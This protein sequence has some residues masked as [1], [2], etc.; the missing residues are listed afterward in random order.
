MKTTPII[1]AL[2]LALTLTTLGSSLTFAAESE[3]E[4]VAQAAG[5][6]SSA[7]QTAINN[8][9]KVAAQAKD[10]NYT[11]QLGLNHYLNQ[12]LD[13]AKEIANGTNA[14]DADAMAQ[15]L[16]EASNATKAFLNNTP[17]TVATASEKVSSEE[18]VEAAAPVAET[19]PQV[20]VATTSTKTTRTAQPAVQTLGTAITV[21]VAERPE[22]D[23]STKNTTST[24]NNST[25]TTSQNAK[26]SDKTN[27]NLE[28]DK[29]EVAEQ[30]NDAEA[31][32]AV[33]VPQTGEPK[34]ASVAT[35]IIAGIAVVAA[36]AGIS[37]V[38]LK[39]KRNV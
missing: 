21:T 28:N 35:L 24:Q 25:K 27:T 5:S 11:K 4:I 13:L 39:G 9:E 20:T 6:S 18:K 34:K 31:N 1:S 19:A 15:V 36:T 10:N 12:K 30:K 22:S 3:S 33:E 38:I 16:N 26:S 23:T 8:A 17:K 32:E 29:A 7:L 14:G 37:A 2:V